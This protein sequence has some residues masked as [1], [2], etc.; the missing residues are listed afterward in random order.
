M[1]FL[2]NSI[3]GIV[4]GL[5]VCLILVLILHNTA[6][7]GKDMMILYLIMFVLF[8]LG[9]GAIQKNYFTLSADAIPSPQEQIQNINTTVSENWKNTNGGFTFEEIKKAQEDSECPIYDDQVIDLKCYDFGSYIVFSYANNGTYQNALFYKSNDGLILDGMINTYA[10]LSGMKW[11]FAY[12]L[13]NF[14]W[15][16]ELNKEPYYY[17]F[18]TF[19]DGRK[20][21]GTHDDL[22]SISRQTQKFVKW[23]H[24]ARTNQDEMVDY[25]MK[26]AADITGKNITSNF[27]KFGDVELIGTADTGF[28]KINSFYNYLY[29]QIKGEGYNNFK[30]IDGSDCLCVPIPEA[31]QV[32]YPISAN[33]KF[34]YANKDYYGVYKCNI[35]VNLSIVKGNE[36]ISSTTDNEDYIDEIKKGEDTKDK[37]KIEDIKPKNTFSKLSLGFVDTKDSNLNNLNL[38][39][40]PIKIT[41]TN[42]LNNQTKLVVIDSVE[43]LNSGVDVLLTKNSTWDYFIDSE[44]LIF[45]DFRGSFTIRSN[46]SN[47]TFDYYFLDNYT[48]ASVGLNPVGTIDKSVINLQDYPVKIILS[49]AEHTYQF[50]FNDN[51]LLDSCQSMLVEMGDYEYTI[52]SKQLIFASVTGKLSFT[53]TDKTMLFNYAL[54]AEDP[55]TFSVVVNKSGSTN[56]FFQLY[57]ESTNVE[58]IRETLSSAKVYIVNYVIYDE[59]GRLIESF[60]HTHA[61][62]GTCSDSWYASNLVHGQ[63]YTLQLRFS[64]RDDSTI[65][66]LSDIATFTFES[67]TS[68]K[69]VYTVTK[70]N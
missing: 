40:T 37:V 42:T 13:S 47:V 66:Y 30:L 59:L 12:D 8:G 21:A 46:A 39:A 29:E 22:V 36:T 67:N 16:Y 7:K 10:S 33:K 38:L 4:V 44:A 52:L 26:N 48:I 18:Y 27:I 41:F 56:E 43:K 60:T 19:F 31:Q 6:F 54:G 64:D 62:S 61:S 50:L 24:G 5:V 1:E 35:A 58:L 11:F 63:Q 25:V 15:V 49:N 20:L 3:V 17:E 14:E 70:N 32:N 65:T 55:L 23:T 45:E 53:T 57:S 9:G 28:V 69:A 34:E 2:T 68:Y 51:S